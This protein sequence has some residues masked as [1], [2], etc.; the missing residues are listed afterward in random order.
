MFE[1]VVLFFVD[2]HCHLEDEAFDK[3]RNEVIRRAYE[4]GVV[5]IINSS[6]DFEGAIKSLRLSLQY[7]GFIF[8]TLGWDPTDLDRDLV[9]KLHSLAREQKYKIVGI[10]EVGLDYYYVR[11]HALRELQQDLF[12]EWIALAKELDL[13]LV[14][15]SRSAGKYALQILFEEGAEKV[16]M[17]AYD[18]RPSWALK[19]AQAG[20]YFSI[21][22]SVWRSRQKQKLVRALPLEQLMLETDSPVLSPILGRRNEPAN[23]LY[24]ARK[25]AEIKGVSVEKVAEITTQNAINFFSLKLGLPIFK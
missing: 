10:G 1:G 4:A 6:L 2:V 14:I 3:D 22:T 18:G 21:P 23:I 8:T 5:A 19:A 13:P 25:V 9:N 11:D 12:R 17:H 24:A 20:Y 15:H 16:L 7:P